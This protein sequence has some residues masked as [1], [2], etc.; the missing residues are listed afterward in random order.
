MSL[1]TLEIISPSIYGELPIRRIAKLIKAQMQKVDHYEWSCLF[2]FSPRLHLIGRW[3][4][5]CLQA[6]TTLQVGRLPTRVLVQPL[7]LL[8]RADMDNIRFGRW[9]FQLAEEDGAVS[10][11]ISISFWFFF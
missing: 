3:I 10:E 7:H 5:G 6:D 1:K 9:W 4:E 2:V 11:V 8:N